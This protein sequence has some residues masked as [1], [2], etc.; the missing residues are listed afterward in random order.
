[1]A[2][3]REIKERIDSIEETSKITNAM[4]LISSTKLR[5]VR[6]ELADTEPY[7]YNLQNALERLIRHTP[8]MEHIFLKNL[9]EIPPEKRKRGLIVV[10]GDKGLAGAYNHN[11]LKMADEWYQS[12]GEHALF[13]I[14]EVGRAYFQGKGIP[15]DTHFRYTAQDPSLHRSRRIVSNFTEKFQNGELDEVSIIYTRMVNS[16]VTEAETRD[17]LPINVHKILAK[18]PPEFLGGEEITFE[19]SQKD[20]IDRVIPNYL[21]GFIFGALVESYT[22]EQNARMMAMQA[23]NDNAAK[24]IN[25]LSIEYN[26]VRQAAITQEITEVV[27]GARAQSRE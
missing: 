8:T 7:F 26:R 11:V 25:E 5:K 1:M 16:M 15:I 27:A 24:M 20:V 14:G 2:N 3:A 21:V 10:T 18:V 6:K 23:A 9:D 4:Y 19:P 13:V 17:L 12:P 22:S